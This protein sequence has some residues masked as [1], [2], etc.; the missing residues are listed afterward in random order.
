MK[1]GKMIYVWGDPTIVLSNFDAGG[2]H[3]D[4]YGVIITSHYDENFTHAGSLE[5]ENCLYIEKDQIKDLVSAIQE[6]LE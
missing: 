6:F 4:A 1:N 2:E 5:N 3:G